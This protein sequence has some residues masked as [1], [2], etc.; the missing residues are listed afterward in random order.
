MPI[1]QHNPQRQCAN[2]FPQAFSS[3]PQPTTAK[4]NAKYDGWNVD[5]PRLFFANGLRD[6]WREATVSADGLDKPST[7][8]TPIFEG[9]GFHCSDLITD[10]GIDDPSVAAVQFSALGYMHEWLA[11][12]KP[13]A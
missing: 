1:H 5:I 12:W 10:S 3:P 13:S 9:D 4:T 6:P 7:P 2:M 11:E 8:S